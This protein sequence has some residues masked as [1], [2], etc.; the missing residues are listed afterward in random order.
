MGFLD[1]NKIKF[2]NM[3]EE[4]WPDVTTETTFDLVCQRVLRQYDSSPTSYNGN[5]I[6]DVFF[7]NL[8]TIES[9]HVSEHFFDVVEVT[10]PEDSE[11]SISDEVNGNTL[12][13][14]TFKRDDVNIDTFFF[15]ASGPFPVWYVRSTLSPW[16]WDTLPSYTGDVEYVLASVGLTE[17]PEQE[18]FVKS[19]IE[20]KWYMPGAI[21]FLDEDLNTVDFKDY[22]EYETIEVKMI[23][24]IRSVDFSAA[25]N[26]L[27]AVFFTFTNEELSRY[28]GIFLAAGSPGFVLQRS[29]NLKRVP[30][31]FDIRK[32]YKITCTFGATSLDLLIEDDSG[33][34]VD[35]TLVAAKNGPGSINPGERILLVAPSGG[36]DIEEIILNGY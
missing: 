22:N 33:I 11:L 20:D 18:M 7:R 1:L 25:D 5:G 23:V 31:E 26:D 35:E 13:N 21:T 3:Y 10:Y 2:P 24:R 8:V 30:Y 36:I 12:A 6:A 34:I 9:T 19:E 32:K 14:W 4:T 15:G 27:G 17:V 28:D 16:T 29:G